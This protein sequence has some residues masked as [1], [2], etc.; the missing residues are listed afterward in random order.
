MEE[1]I[2]SINNNDVRRKMFNIKKIIFY[3]TI[4]VVSLSLVYFF[5]FS[6]PSNF[7]VPS[8][9]QIEP[10][11]SLRSISS[12]LKKDQIIRSRIA[13]EYLA[14]FSGGE[15]RIVSA[16]Y[17]FDKKL[18]VWQVGAARAGP[19]RRQSARA[20]GLRLNGMGCSGCLA[21]NHAGAHRLPPNA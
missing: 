16:D 2:E 7:P 1:N 3:A 15:K 20:R 5:F 6:A 17:L 13:F 19:A 8:V 14:I 11:M 12:L 4:L 10:G 9:I 21:W 18:P